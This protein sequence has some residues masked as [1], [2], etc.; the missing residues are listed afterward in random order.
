[1][2]ETDTKIREQSSI[3]EKV[4]R[5][6][7]KKPPGR[8]KKKNLPQKWRALGDREPA[9]D[10]APDCSTQTPSHSPLTLHGMWHQSG[11][12]TPA[13]HGNKGPTTLQLQTL[14]QGLVIHSVQVLTDWISSDRKKS[15]ISG[16]FLSTSCTW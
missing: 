11:A 10:R 2:G 12:S 1:M 16:D 8:Q 6:A 5:Q 7:D 13:Q 3:L 4:S 9:K 15:S 14:G